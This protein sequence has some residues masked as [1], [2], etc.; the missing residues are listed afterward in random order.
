M[1]LESSVSGVARLSALALLAV[2]TACGRTGEDY[3]HNVLRGLDQGKVVGTKGTMEGL[4]RALS[5]YSVDKGGYPQATSIE[6]AMSALVP[7]FMPTPVAPDA[8]G[9][10]LAYRS[11]GKTFTLTAPGADG[12]V[13]TADD[14]VMVDGSF[15]QLPAPS[16][17][18]G[19]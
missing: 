2:L 11:D 16:A 13:G 5:A 17:P 9:H 12:Q 4:A 18:S 10:P 8:W 1:L 7:A 14:L 15:T 6:Q 19:Q 3:A